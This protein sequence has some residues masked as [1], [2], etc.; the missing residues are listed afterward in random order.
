MCAFITLTVFSLNA[1]SVSN[2]DVGMLTF[3]PNDEG[4]SIV[5]CDEKAFGEIVIPETYNGKPITKIIRSAFVD[6]EYIT[7]VV[8]PDTVTYIG[9]GAFQG[10]SALKTVKL[11]NNLIALGD[12][13]F[14]WCKSLESIELPESLTS[15]GCYVIYGW[16]KIKSITIPKN[17][18]EIG[19]HN[20]VYCSK[21][22]SIQV[23]EGNTTF[24]I[25]DCGALYDLSNATILIYPLQSER[26]SYSIREGTTKINSQAFC[27]ANIKHIYIPSSV[28]LIGI[29]AFILSN[30]N[31]VCYSGTKS[32]W[33]KIVIA[34]ENDK[35]SNASFFYHTHNSSLET[36][37]INASPASCFDC[38]YT[39][40]LC[41]VECGFV[42]E[43]GETIDPYGEHDWTE[44]IVEPSCISKGYTLH[45]CS[46]CNER[47]VSDEKEKLN[48][49]FKTKKTEATCVKA[50]YTTYECENCHYKYTSEDISPKG[51]DF[52]NWVII[53]QP[54]DTQN[55]TIERTCLECGLKETALL[56]KAKT[57][58]LK[59]SD[60]TL[61][62]NY[63]DTYNLTANKNVKWASSDTKVA[64]VNEKTGSVNAKGEGTATIT[65]TTIDGNENAS[66]IVTV[67][68]TFFQRIV[69]FFLSLFKMFQ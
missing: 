60:E 52:T 47:Y 54:T 58:N 24:Y 61:S 18:A 33:E 46:R 7:K 21:L 59:I 35:L 30:I 57:T 22:E 16:E 63:E 26:K 2:F 62:L 53:K 40:D 23:E 15:I 44:T 43:N 56:E 34:T 19:D 42:I 65:A 50:G 29:E 10:C 5:Q 8:I 11:S 25:D 32:Q 3:E 36:E 37:I 27:H 12:F 45:I 13:A 39:G 51:H 66:C 55:G 14:N 20:F 68:V 4:Y 38:G 17:V 67:K 28:V 69:L 41:Y 31:S 1:A 64:V 49:N 48:H 6:N 9:D